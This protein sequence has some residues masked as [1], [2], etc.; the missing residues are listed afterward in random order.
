MT[1]LP[2]NFFAKTALY[3]AVAFLLF[4]V[5]AFGQYGYSSAS[6]A[7]GKQQSVQHIIPR[8]EHIVTPEYINY[9][10]HNIPLP[11]PNESVHLDLRW[12]NSRLVQDQVLQ[13]GITTANGDGYFDRQPVNISLVIDRSGSM[14]GEKIA[15][16]REA[17]LTF[18]N[19]LQFDDLLSIVVF[20][21]IVEVLQQPMPV[22]DKYISEKIIK[23]IH[24]RGSTD[25]NAG[26]IE[27]YRQVISKYQKG[28]TN[29]VI[30]LTDAMTNTGTLNL[31]TIIKHSGIYEAG[32]EVDFVFIGVGMDINTDLARQ[33]SE[34][35]KNTFHFIHDPADINKVF[36][37]EVESLLAQVGRN[38]ELT[39]RY[40]NKLAFKDA[41]G[42]PFSVGE[43]EIR[44]ALN[45]LNGGLTQVVLASFLKDYSEESVTVS[46]AYDD[47]RSGKRVTQTR[48]IGSPAGM[49]G[50][51][52]VQKNVTIA[53][54]AVSLQQMAELYHKGQHGEAQFALR[55]A[56]NTT[57]ESGYA[58][59][60]DVKRVLD[61]LENYA[62]DLSELVR[63][64]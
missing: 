20:D 38:V 52:E 42:Q 14:E 23:S 26:I 41:F 34:S 24:T 5:S 31:E 25:L 63:K 43:K 56:I 9:H 6:L 53:Q 45:N 64:D 48:T 33:L 61:I 54:M 15:R 13:I 7:M 58:S 10:K 57:R 12:D 51:P 40:G 46:L 37:A 21:H 2:V 17:M 27:G 59:D 60:P 16:T 19:H 30:I 49:V 4:S 11:S 28:R 29:R 50:D 44:F 35:K 32:Y 22:G 36:N 18:L 55:Q 3:F 62:G 8:P 1:L 47:M 39:I